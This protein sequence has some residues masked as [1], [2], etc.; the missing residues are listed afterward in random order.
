MRMSPQ[1]R[2]GSLAEAPSQPDAVVVSV[3]RAEPYL[4]VVLQKGGIHISH[5]GSLK[6]QSRR[7]TYWKDPGPKDQTQQGLL[8]PVWNLPTL[9]FCQTSRDRGQKWLSTSRVK[10]HLLQHA[11][12]TIANTEIPPA[13]SGFGGKHRRLPRGATRRKKGG[14]GS[15]NGRSVGERN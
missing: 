4:R 14:A 5:A 7:S 12:P 9:K 2:I 15:A 11:E 8:K 10:K 6:V 3:C 1:S 13:C